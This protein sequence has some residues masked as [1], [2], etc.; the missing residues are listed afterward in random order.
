MATFVLMDDQKVDLGV[1]GTDDVGNPVT[2]TGAPTWAVSDPTILT[3]TPDAT[4][5][6]KATVAATGKIGTAQVSVSVAGPPPLTG[7]L[8]VQVTSSAATSLGISAGTPVHV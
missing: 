2:F 4:D 7:T 3:V 1:M 8:D 6:S 5:P